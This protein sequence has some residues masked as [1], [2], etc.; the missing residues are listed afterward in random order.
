MELY[1]QQ[2][3]TVSIETHSEKYSVVIVYINDSDNNTQL[4]AL[5]MPDSYYG[6]QVILSG[7]IKTEDVTDGYTGLWMRGGSQVAFDNMYQ[8]RITGSIRKVVEQNIV[9]Q[10]Q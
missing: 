1:I 5:D 7:Y 4:I 2:C 6:Q 8:R 9:F 10:N 3:Y